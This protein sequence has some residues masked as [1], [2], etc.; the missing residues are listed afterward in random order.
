MPFF[1]NYAMLTGLGLREA[2]TA[3]EAV[4]A[5]REI[6]DAGG[7]RITIADHSGRLFTVEQ[8]IVPAPIVN[9]VDV[10]YR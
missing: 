6:R 2:A 1:L 9:T 10:A 8:L 3:M 5:Y 7:G 4:V